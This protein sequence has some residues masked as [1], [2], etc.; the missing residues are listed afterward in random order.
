[1]LSTVGSVKRGSLSTPGPT[2]TTLYFFF[3]CQLVPTNQK[4]L[5]DVQQQPTRI[6]YDGSPMSC[7]A[8]YLKILKSVFE[9]DNNIHSY[10]SIE[11]HLVR[12]GQ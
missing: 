4:Q 7:G 12:S 8:L 6:L 10:W 11:K 1:M 2:R 3:M 9:T 5:D